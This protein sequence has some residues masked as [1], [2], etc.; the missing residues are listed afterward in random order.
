MEM[1]HFTL[2]KVLYKPGFARI[3]PGVRVETRAR[4][5]GRKKGF[6]MAIWLMGTANRS[7]PLVGEVD[8]LE[9]PAGT[10]HG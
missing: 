7:W 3:L 8:I 9:N 5:R 4:L 10:D 2:A 6:N 1:Q